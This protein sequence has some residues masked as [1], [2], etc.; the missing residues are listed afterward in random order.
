MTSKTV[1]L[2]EKIIVSL[3]KSLLSLIKKQV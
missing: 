2:L 1:L 3:N